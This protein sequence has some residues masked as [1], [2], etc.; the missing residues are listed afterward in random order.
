MIKD[1]K[2]NKGIKGA[3]LLDGV[4]DGTQL[5]V[6]KVPSKFQRFLI[7]KILGWGFATID[8][9]AKKK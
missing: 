8:V 9:L 4:L 5:A 1:Q 2:M 6:S 7:K 3:Y